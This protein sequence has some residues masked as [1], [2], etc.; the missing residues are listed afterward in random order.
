MMLRRFTPLWI[1]LS[2]VAATIGV[3][4]SSDRPWAMAQAPDSLLAQNRTTI[5]P[6]VLAEIRQGPFSQT[7]SL[8]DGVAF[9]IKDKDYVPSMPA[10][11]VFSLWADVPDWQRLEMVMKYCVSNLQIVHNQASLVEVELLAGDTSLATLDQVLE[12]GPARISEVEPPQVS[13]VNTAVYYDPF[14][15]TYFAS[16]FTF[17]VA[18]APMVTL[19]AVDCS[20][21]TTRF[22]LMPVREALATLPSQT[23]TMRL[24]FS[25]GNT[26]NWRLGRGTVNA[27]KELPSVQP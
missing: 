16:P 22:D 15:N 2:A 8:A 13:S 3:L 11:G 27:L 17:G 6:K 7:I 25:D 23:L 26:E 21:G 18:Y 14:Y 4:D 24:L 20:A 1:S 9:A 10:M 12:S 19:P 5:P